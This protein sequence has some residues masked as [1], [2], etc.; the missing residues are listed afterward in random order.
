MGGRKS[1]IRLKDMSL[2]ENNQ[3]SPFAP[4]RVRFRTYHNDGAF[5]WIKDAQFLVLAG[6]EDARAV[7]VPAGAV[8][9]VGVYRLNSHR[10]LTA[11]HVPQDHHVITACEDRV[12]V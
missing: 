4:S 7:C 5:A 9:Q 2:W 10:G 6:R 8:D 11:S 12:R 1:G 3:R